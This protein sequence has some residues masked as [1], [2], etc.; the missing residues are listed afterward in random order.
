LR[1]GSGDLGKRYNQ[2]RFQRLDI[3]WQLCKIIIHEAKW[4]IRF[5]TGASSF[6]AKGADFFQLI[7]RP[8]GAT[9]VAD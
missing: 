7:P 1:L 4:I 5:V 3:V 2:R 8:V 9:C 6:L